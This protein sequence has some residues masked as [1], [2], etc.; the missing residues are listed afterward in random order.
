MEALLV[1]LNY[2]QST[3]ESLA[4]GFITGLF[5]AIVIAIS[6]K[7][8]ASRKNKTKWDEIS[9]D[10]NQNAINGIQPDWEETRKDND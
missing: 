1:F 7:I 2:H 3:G 6:R 9:K 10:E 5:I 8:K 4:Q